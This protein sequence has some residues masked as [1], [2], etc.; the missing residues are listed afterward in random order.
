M[1]FL[2]L[3]SRLLSLLFL[4]SFASYTS[5][6]VA[7][8]ALDSN[9]IPYPIFPPQLSECWPCKSLRQLDNLQNDIQTM[10]LRNII[11]M[12][13]VESTHCL[14]WRVM[15][16]VRTA[17]SAFPDFPVVAILFSSLHFVRRIFTRLWTRGNPNLAL[18]ARILPAFVIFQTPNRVQISRALAGILP[19]S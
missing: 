13:V 10:P 16:R 1:I 14:I 7:V 9:L 15:S 2:P 18:L 12:K 8:K 6:S 17:S 3:F 5:I 11:R 4:L 19:T